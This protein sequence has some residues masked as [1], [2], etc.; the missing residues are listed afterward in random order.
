MPGSQDFAADPRNAGLKVWLNGKL[1]LKAEATVSVFDAGFVLGDGVWEGLRLHKG[2]L[3]FL[4][5]HLDRLYAGANDIQLH[6]GLTRDQ[7]IAALNATLAANQ[8][9]HGAH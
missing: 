1:V 9:H 2:A 7:M 5:A 6:L 4:D 8:M 3:I